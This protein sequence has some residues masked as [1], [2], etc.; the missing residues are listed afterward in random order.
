MRPE[1]AGWERGGQRQRSIGASVYTGHLDVS[2]PFH[3]R[4]KQS[5]GSCLCDE[6]EWEERE[7]GFWRDH[8]QSFPDVYFHSSPWTHV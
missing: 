3:W 8:L 4:G 1:A 7:N 2:W 5:I 6:F